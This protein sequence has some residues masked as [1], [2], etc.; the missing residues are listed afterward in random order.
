MRQER[1]KIPKKIIVSVFVV[2]VFLA[3]ILLVDRSPHKRYSTPK[4]IQTTFVSVKALPKVPAAKPTQK[5]AQKSPQ[6]KPLPVQEK[7][8]VTKKAS[9]TQVK[10]AQKVPEKR[11][12]TKKTEVKPQ[13]KPTATAPNTQVAS[14]DTK[15][16]SVKAQQT[17]VS[18][19]SLLYEQVKSQ[20]KLKHA[21]RVL[22]KVR[23]NNRGEVLKCKVIEATDSELVLFTEQQIMSLHF[24]AFSHE[25][26]RDTEHE[27]TLE[28]L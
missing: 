15:K 12:V 18:Y 9:V 3:T 19:A 5:L 27:F 4:E 24:P 7:P 10:M 20:V 26:A 21:G 16:T 22:L 23:L 1:L 13:K 2:H 11:Q 14:T 28:L 6:A 25:R 8:K 17:Q